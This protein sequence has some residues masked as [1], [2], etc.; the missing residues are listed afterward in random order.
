MRWISTE[1]ITIGVAAGWLLL[2]TSVLPNKVSNYSGRL[3]AAEPEPMRM[4]K[5]PN[6]PA[7]RQFLSWF[8]ERRD[9]MIARVRELVELESPSNNKQSVDRLGQALASCFE[10]LGGRVRFHRQEKFGDHLQVDFDGAERAKP[11]LLLGHHDTVWDLGTI[12]TMPFRVQKGRVWGPG[13]LDMKCGLVMMM[14]AIEAWRDL[15]GGL[16]RAVTVLSNTDEEV[17]SESSRVITEELA[18]GSAAVLVLEPAQG[19]QGALK[20]ARKGVGDYRVRVIGQAS[21]AGVDFE[22]GRSAI[23]ELARQIE[24]IA[25]FTEL[26]RGLTVNVGVIRGGTRTNVVAAEAVAEVDIRIARVADAARIE[27]K[28]RGLKPVDRGCKLEVSGGLNRPPMERSAGIAALFGTARQVA[29]ELGWELAEAA[30]GGGSDGNF[31]AALGLATLDGLGAVGEG[32]HATHE[33][34]LIEELPRRGALLAS[35]LSRIV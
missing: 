9:D 19:L 3:C 32:A 4:P 31:T 24:R 17:G 21:H 1:S 6:A 14:F 7:P 25:G 23:H 28:F 15:N 11:V 29:G 35:L 22:K 18:K 5:P 34:L 8:E 33:S 20:T 13:A 26:Q 16:A 2:D 10:K 12:R 27:K 30:T